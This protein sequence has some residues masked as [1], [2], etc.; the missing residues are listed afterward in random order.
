L[1]GRSKDNIIN[2]DLQHK[3]VI[4][5]LF[6]EESGVNLAHNKS[7]ES[8]KSLN[9]SYNALGACFNP[10]KAFPLLNFDPIASRPLASNKN[11]MQ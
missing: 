4:A 3:Q 1:I 6:G 2:I 7:L 9:L 8:R 11:L 5:N 10:Y